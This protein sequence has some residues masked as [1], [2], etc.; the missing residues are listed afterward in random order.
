M[1]QN[2]FQDILDFHSKFNVP[3]APQHSLLEGEALEFRLNF[4]QEELDELRKAHDEG[5][6]EDAVDALIDLEVVLLGTVQFMGISPEAYQ[7][8]WD[9]VHRANMAKER[10]TDASQ[11][12]RGTSLDIFKPAGWT[13]PD[14]AP[15]ISK[16]LGE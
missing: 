10:C 13:A 4:L 7:E 12:K 16:Y 9:E 15:I 2:H 14:H 8:H 5:N 11:S 1:S 3:L 6:L